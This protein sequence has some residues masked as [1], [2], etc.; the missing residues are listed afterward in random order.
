MSPLSVSDRSRCVDVPAY[1]TPDL[2]V[3]VWTDPD[4]A[5]RV[6][7]ALDDF[8]FGGLGLSAADFEDPDM[9]VQLGREPQRIDILT[10][11]TGL[12]FEQAYAAR[13]TIEIGGVPVPIVSVD[14]LRRCHVHGVVGREVVPHF[15][16]PHQH[17][18][19]E[20]DSPKRPT[21]HALDSSVAVLLGEQTRPTPAHTNASLRA[22][23]L[24]PQ[25]RGYLE[26]GQR[27]HDVRLVVADEFDQPFP[28]AMSDRSFAV[29][30]RAGEQRGIDD[31]VH[32][33]R[34]AVR[35]LIAQRQPTRDDRRQSGSAHCLPRSPRRIRPETSPGYPLGS[36]ATSFPNTA[37]SVGA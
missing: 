1:F 19:R 25:C 34:L 22:M 17:R 35:D 33:S 20:V 36:Q 28:V 26:P 12:S 15:P 9:V 4:N 10:F 7:Q 6:I 3:W 16:D 31:N 18:L 8:G 21:C 24:V 13:M 37:S 29:D 27:A 14:D 11:A 23:E 2:D 5:S 32:V 30:E